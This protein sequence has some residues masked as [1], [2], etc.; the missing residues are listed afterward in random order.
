MRAHTFDRQIIILVLKREMIHL[1]MFAF[2]STVFNDFGPDLPKG[3]HTYKCD[4]FFF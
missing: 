2:F 3:L 1:L 4:F